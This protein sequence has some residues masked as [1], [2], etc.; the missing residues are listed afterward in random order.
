[1]LFRSLAAVL[2][3]IAGDGS[4]AL[5]GGSVAADIVARVRGHARNPGRLSLAD[6]SAYQALER[7]PLCTDWA[8]IYRV[9]GM[10]PPS[11]GHVTMMQILG[12]LAQRDALSPAPALQTAMQ[13][14]VASDASAALPTATWLHT[15][16][17][18]SRL[19]FADRAQYLADP[20]FTAPPSGGWASLLDDAYLHR[21]AA[22]I[23]AQ[24]MRSAPAG[25]PGDPGLSPRAQAP[26][27]EQPEFGTSHVSIVDGAGH[28]LA[29]TTT[30][31]YAFGTG[32]LSDGGT[33]LAGGFLLNNQLTD[34]S[35][36]PADAA[37]LP[38]ANRVQP[39]KRPR[40][41]MT[42]TLV[43]DRRDGRL[44]M[45]LGSAGGPAIIHHTAK[46]LIGSLAWGLDLQSAFGLPNV[47]TFEALV[48]L[49]SGRFPA[50]T[51]QALKDRGHPV[52]E[53]D[54][55]SGLQGFQRA[56]G[57]WLGAADPRREGAALGD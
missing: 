41:S 5:H 38:I 9:C 13:A 27:P 53:A 54:F 55:A 45:S 34:F 29:M 25:H 44:L 43:F 28:A 6:L 31:E 46:A 57:G 20:A 33:G 7:E 17:E 32:V 40:S 14:A 12:L 47:G 48:V 2:R 50:A 1:M 23:G 18:A 24:A 42:P 10:P 26:Q 8:L 35:F 4:A 52:R 3:A 36:A 56:S 21:R 16:V 22:L 11:S 39:G 37:G 51:L 15:Y 30:I 19:A 49:E